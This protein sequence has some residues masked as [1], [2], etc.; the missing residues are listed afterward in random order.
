MEEI[1]TLVEM[2]NKI[3][4]SKELVQGG[5]GNTSVKTQDGDML[6][7]ASG[8][9]FSEM[10]KDT[11]FAILNH[12]IIVDSFEENESSET[13][14][15]EIKYNRS[16]KDSMIDPSYPRPSMETGMHAFLD[17]IVIHTHPIMVNIITCSSDGKKIIPEILPKETNFLWLDYVNPGYSLAKEVGNKVIEYENENGEKPKIIILKNHGIIVSGK[18]PDKCIDTTFKLN[19]LAYEYL[20]GKFGIEGFP[21]LQI[22]N[23][24]IFYFSDNTAIKKFIEN[25]NE[26]KSL[27]SKFLIPDDVIYCSKFSLHENAHNLDLDKINIVNNQGIFY[28]WNEKKSR[29]VDE[30]FTAKLYA[31]MVLNKFGKIDFLKDENVNYL[32]NMDSEKYRQKLN[33]ANK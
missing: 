16:L 19:Q 30:I 22:R 17:N 26:N 18:D 12:K 3:G 9:T 4:K 27:L 24:D 11:G 20:K 7:K 28:P 10:T 33:E 6:I 29:N 2:S 15:N 8:F 32:L 1:K 31:L 25:I 14:E 5:G 23:R 21:E 13:E